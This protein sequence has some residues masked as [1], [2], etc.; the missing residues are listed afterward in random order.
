MRLPHLLLTALA[1]T[2]STAA[3]PAQ[4]VRIASDVGLTMDGGLL[5]VIYGQSCGA[6]TCT[7]FQAGNVGAGQQR[8]VAI[9]GAPLQPYALA[10]DLAT[11]QC[12]TFPGFFNQLLVSL[13]VTLAVG[14]I[15]PGSATAVCPQGRAGYGLLFPPGT[16]AGY[17][18]VLQGVAM[19]HGLR[20]PAFTVG[21]AGRTF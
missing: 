12:I 4:A 10:I 8:T 1:L 6:F 21:I 19:S 13:P 18:F 9:Y 11:P 3:L 17:D 20:E 2:T 15:G 5:T 14:M 7:P 16:P